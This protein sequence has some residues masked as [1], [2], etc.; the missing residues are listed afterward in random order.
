MRAACQIA[1]K[2]SLDH[3]VLAYS[4]LI[5]EAD[6]QKCRSKILAHKMN[7]Q[8]INRIR[9]WDWY[10]HRIGL[11]SSYADNLV[12]LV[13]DEKTPLHIRA[14]LYEIGRAFWGRKGRCN[15]RDDILPRA[16]P[17][18]DKEARGIFEDYFRESE[19]TEEKL[20]GYDFLDMFY[21]EHRC[22]TW[23]SEVLQGTDFAFNTH[24]FISCR[25]AIELTLQAPFEDRLDGSLFSK[26]I[27]M[28]APELSEMPI[29]GVY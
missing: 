7:R 26:V 16:K 5:D 22:G 15:K 1:E 10:G 8:S 3:Y 23:I 13:R 11:A 17:Q 20:C 2:M 25:K 27:S 21:W 4:D 14:N 6:A 18:W 19:F 24:S 9:A 29:N 12:P 28:G